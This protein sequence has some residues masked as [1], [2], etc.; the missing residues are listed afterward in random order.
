MK[1]GYSSQLLGY[2]QNREETHIGMRCSEVDG[3]VLRYVRPRNEEWHI[4]IFLKSALFAWL[5][6]VL[7]DMKTIVAGVYHVRIL[8]HTKNLEFV[9]DSAHKLIDRLQGL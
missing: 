1:L 5:Q 8:V 7:A 3:V 9:K 6:P 2:A 4:D